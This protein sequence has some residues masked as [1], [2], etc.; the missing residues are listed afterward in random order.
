MRAQAE[1]AMTMIARVVQAFV[2]V[3]VG[4][5]LLDWAGAGKRAGLRYV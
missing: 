1:V 4:F 3:I 5:R 2:R